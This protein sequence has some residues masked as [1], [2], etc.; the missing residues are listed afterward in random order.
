MRIGIGFDSHKFI[1]GNGFYLGGVKIKFHRKLEGISDA[2]V[3]IHALSDALLGAMGEKDIGE[4]FPEQD[5]L[6]IGRKS[7]EFLEIIK[8][9]LKNRGYD[10]ENIDIVIILKEPML[11]EYKQAIKKNLAAIL[12]IPEDKIALKAKRP[13]GLPLSTEDGISSF[14]AVLLNK[15][16]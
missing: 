8:Q 10:I 3:L 11:K 15:K 13:E 7:T 2:D 6:N 1:K 4:H 9:K 5:P 14:V 16:Y 12:K